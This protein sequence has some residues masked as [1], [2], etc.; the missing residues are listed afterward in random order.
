MSN[1]F[2]RRLYRRFMAMMGIF[3]LLVCVGSIVLISAVQSIKTSYENDVKVSSLKQ[4]AVSDIR[5]HLDQLMIRV[6]GYYAY[7]SQDEYQLIFK[8]KEALSTVIEKYQT[9]SLTAEEQTFIRDVNAFLDRY[10]NVYLPQGVKY[11]EADDYASL[12]RMYSDGLDKSVNG[13]F[14]KA[15]IFVNDSERRLDEEND[16]LLR[17]LAEIDYWFIGFTLF[18][19]AVA[20]LVFVRMVKD[21]TKPLG[22]LAASADHFTGGNEV[23]LSAVKRADEIGVLA[24]SLDEMMRE[25][26][27][28]EEELLA[29]NEELLTQQDELQAQQDELQQ[30]LQNM[31]ENERYLELRNRFI[32]S[33]SNTLDLNELLQSVVR[34]MAEALHA[35]MGMVV[36]LNDRL[37]HASYLVPPQGVKQLVEQAG[38]GGMMRLREGKKPYVITRDS[39]APEKGYHV[40]ESLK[41]YDLYVPVLSQH[42][43]VVAALVFTRIGH[44]FGSRESAEAL[45]LSKPISL[46]LDKIKMHQET[47]RLSRLTQDMLN[48][49]QEGVQ[50]VTDD[51]VLVQVNDKMC[52]F[53]HC[54][55]FGDM[56]NA[57]LERFYTIVAEKTDDGPRIKNFM[58]A[59]IAGREVKERTL[60]YELT[61]PEYRVIHMYFEPLYQGNAR[62]G[63]LF[64]HR[65]ITKEHEV[66]KMKS[67]FVSTVSHELRTP[68][69]SVLGFTELLLN[70]EFSPER[71]KKYLTTIHKEANRL[72]SLINDFLDVQRME[73]GKQTYEK[74]VLDLVP[75]LSDL[76]DTVQVNASQH[77][78]VLNLQTDHMHINADGDKMRQIFTNLLSNAVKY[79][80]DGGDVTVSV[81]ENKDT[82]YI[83][84]ADKGLG[85]PE[86]SLSKLFGKFFRI[87][88]SDR[89]E[90]GGTGLGLAIVKEIVKAHGGDV[91]V[92]SVM[93]E[94]SVF[95]VALP[96]ASAAETA[97]AKEEAAVAAITDAAGSGSGVSLVI[98]EDDTSLSELLTAELQEY[99][100]RVHHFV[101]GEDALKEIAKLKPDAVVVDL[102]LQASMDGWSII[103]ELKKDR[104]TAHIPVFISSALD[105]RTKGSEYGVASYLIKPYRPAMLPQVIMQTLINS[106]KK[107]H[108]MFPLDAGQDSAKS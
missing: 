64:V 7:S 40:D 106:S 23:E 15:E 36:L 72:T 42:D 62:F 102:M 5:L 48:T 53:Y 91:T 43:E 95:T 13:L 107:G 20:T 25:I 77:R 100:F 16:E 67:E 27:L 4:K 73:S 34:N 11:A 89:R 82:A 80:P 78:I 9:M 1:Y 86:E 90:I 52:E 75:I 19:M 14:Q 29:Q 61:S 51:G 105:E 33:L 50:L 71:Q 104:E 45:G 103:S 12:S 83:D 28:K 79:S 69:A 17:V 84:V 74:Q 88:N 21:I 46:S 32:Q 24:R 70:K 68:L 57:S 85:I 39:Y 3:V 108:V 55:E 38:N 98:I 26:R 101:N 96:K 10:Y 18:T 76:V 94:G 35:E 6:R 58:N 65:D 8:E 99:G 49:I 81:R 44:P 22:E 31:E 54:Q 59:I 66:D 30:A 47:E 93:G 97:Q 87:D 60:V 63:T 56:R 41:S 2:N 92:K 37:D